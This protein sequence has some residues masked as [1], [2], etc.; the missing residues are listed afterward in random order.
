M[1]SGTGLRL[2]RARK[3][4]RA[5]SQLENEKS[6]AEPEYLA[7]AAPNIRSDSASVASTA[8]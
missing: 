5:S 6:A 7:N 1:I 8:S 3:Y 4:R 2:A